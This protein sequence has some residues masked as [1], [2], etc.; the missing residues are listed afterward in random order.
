VVARREI[1]KHIVGARRLPSG[2]IDVAFIAPQ[3]IDEA[4][5]F[6]NKLRSRLA[7]DGTIWVIEPEPTA[8][9]PS[10]SAGPA[11]RLADALVDAGWVV[12]D[13]V[14]RVAIYRLL[15]FTLE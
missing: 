2:S 10:G 8:S 14:G 4:R 9:M 3:S 7:P 5:Y 13:I 1:E 11:E 12:H 6:V 15:R